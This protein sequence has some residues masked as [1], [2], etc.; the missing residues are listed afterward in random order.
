[1]T[2]DSCSRLFAVAEKP[3]FPPDKNSS[4]GGDTKFSAGYIR[5]HGDCAKLTTAN[6]SSL[7]GIQNPVRKK[8]PTHK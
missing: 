2:S 3:S 6:S 8:G 5:G 7:E 1:M 4:Y